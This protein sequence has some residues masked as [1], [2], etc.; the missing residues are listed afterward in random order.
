MFGIVDYGS[1]V[2]SSILLNLTPGSDVIYVLSRSAVGG[3]RKGIASALGICTGILIH[4]LLAAFGLS[5]VLA[6]SSVAFNIMKLIGAVYLVFMGV[7]A[8]F[9]DSSI[10]NSNPAN[11]SET[12]LKTYIQG[13][14]TNALNPKVA[15]FFLAL[16]PQFVSPD[17]AYGFLPFVILGLTFFTTSTVWCIILALV[18][19]PISGLLNKTP[20]TGN[21]ANKVA[22]GI[23]IL[24][25]LKVLLQKM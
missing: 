22:G 12:T 14:L 3:R 24:L 10:F 15:L 9:S 6:T 21:V 1:F 13:I 16:M 23:Y 5:A 4:T 8:I 17:N 20:K 2:V 7:K 19:S 11:N 18:S 25:G